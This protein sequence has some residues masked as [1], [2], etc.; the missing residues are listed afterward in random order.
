MGNHKKCD[1]RSVTCLSVVCSGEVGWLYW[2]GDGKGKGSRLGD[3][4][5]PRPG[6]VGDWGY[7]SGRDLGPVTWVHAHPSLP[8]KDMGL[9]EV[10][11]DGNG[12][13]PG[14]DMGPAEVLLDGDG[15]PA[16]W[17]R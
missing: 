15:A 9:V 10:L 2:P 4:G 14:N 11:W 6:L 7:P 3:K 12:A 17:W 1:S 5:V 13:L 8:K 16:G